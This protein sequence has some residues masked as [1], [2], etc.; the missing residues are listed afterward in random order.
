[1]RIT[2]KHQNNRFDGGLQFILATTSSFSRRDDGL[3][4]FYMLPLFYSTTQLTNDAACA[5]RNQITL[6]VPVLLQA[7]R[8]QNT[9]HLHTV[10]RHHDTAYAEGA[11]KPLLC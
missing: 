6:P 9:I 3:Y 4:S 11:R 2:T 5:S 1:M 8:D 10:K 7:F